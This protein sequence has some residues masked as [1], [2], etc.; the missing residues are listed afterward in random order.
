M[1]LKLFICSTPWLIRFVSDSPAFRRKTAHQ[2]RR[3]ISSNPQRAIAL[4]LQVKLRATHLFTAS[5]LLKLSI[6]Q[7]N[8]GG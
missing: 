7:C 3:N 1:R 8:D 4:T 5:L 2:N 6:E